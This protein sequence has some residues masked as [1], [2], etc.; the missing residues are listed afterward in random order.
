VRLNAAAPHSC[1]AATRTGT[2]PATPVVL[3]RTTIC[4]VM[5]IASF[6]TRWSQ[7]KPFHV[8]FFRILGPV[9]ETRPG[10][11]RPADSLTADSCSLATQPPTSDYAE[12]PSLTPAGVHRLPLQ[13]TPHS[14]TLLF[15]A[16]ASAPRPAQPSLSRMVGRRPETAQCSSK[17][18]EVKSNI[19]PP[20]SPDSASVTPQY[21]VACHTCV[22]VRVGYQT[23]V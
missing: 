8:C 6:F 22:C 17:S 12:R 20:G 16:T 19:E 13:L 2:A 11:S 21:R 9:H 4:L 10:V 3:Q 15:S 14:N 7:S 1:L 23:C 18:G 5:L